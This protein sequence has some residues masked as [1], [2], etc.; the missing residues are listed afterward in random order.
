MYYYLSQCSLTDPKN[1]SPAGSP[2]SDN[3][4]LLGVCDIDPAGLSQPAGPQRAGLLSAAPRPASLWSAPA[5]LSGGPL[6]SKG[7]NETIKNAKE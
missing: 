4:A 2:P 1:L 3:V 7:I 6:S 5:A